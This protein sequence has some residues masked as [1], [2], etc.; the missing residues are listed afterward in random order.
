[1][2]LPTS[3]RESMVEELDDYIEGLGSDPN[4]ESI[5]AYVIE[6]LE[7]WA[8]E[9]GFDDI[10][11]ELEDNGALDDPLPDTLEEEISSNE[12]FEFTGEEVVS[13]LETICEIEWEDDEDDEEDDD[14]DEEDDDLDDEL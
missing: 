14:D 4:P 9:E 6:L 3:L 12:E 10:K 8:D 13:L 1:M 5:V 11:G 2:Q 7:I